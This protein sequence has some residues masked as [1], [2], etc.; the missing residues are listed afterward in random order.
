MFLLLL[1]PV[2]RTQ[3]SNKHH[4]LKPSI[5]V[6]LQ[7]PTII[8]LPRIACAGFHSN[9]FTKGTTTSDK[10]TEAKKPKASY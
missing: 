4:W 5:I 2:H 8:H 7:R 3:H 9:S 10:D 1:N 6:V